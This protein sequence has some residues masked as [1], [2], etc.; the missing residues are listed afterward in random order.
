[1]GKKLEVPDQVPG[2]Q[3]LLP[4]HHLPGAV[5]EVGGPGPGTWKTVSSTFTLTSWSSPRGLYQVTMGSWAWYLEDSISNL[6]TIF[7]E[8]SLRPLPGSY[9]E[10]VGGPLPGTW[11]IVSS[12]FTTM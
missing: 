10:D 4:L 12:T 1:M 6:Y 2:R 5:Q 8:Q 9:G 11:R 3:Y 7:L